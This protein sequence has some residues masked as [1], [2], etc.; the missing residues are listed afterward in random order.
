MSIGIT[1]RL[2][3]L[4]TNLPILSN[5]AG[6]PRHKPQRIAPNGLVAVRHHQLR[7]IL[8]SAEARPEF[9]ACQAHSHDQYERGLRA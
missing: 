2:Q 6:L 9:G 8:E 5:A 4:P 7:I 1:P 3:K